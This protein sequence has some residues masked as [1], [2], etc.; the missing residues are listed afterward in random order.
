MRNQ[1]I[2]NLAPPEESR[3]KNKKLRGLKSRI[4]KETLLYDMLDFSIFMT[5]PGN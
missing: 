2:R 5:F 1:L 3:P 4:L